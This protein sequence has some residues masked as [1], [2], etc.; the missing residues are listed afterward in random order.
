MK[1]A[2]DKLLY[3][4]DPDPVV[5]ARINQ[6]ETLLDAELRY[7]PAAAS[8]GCVQFLHWKGADDGPA[9]QTAEFRALITEYSTIVALLRM[10]ET[11]GLGGHLDTTSHLVRP[12]YDGDKQLFVQVL[13]VPINMTPRVDPPGVNKGYNAYLLA[14]RVNHECAKIASW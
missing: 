11:C 10:A 6:Y 13:S 3:F 9:A 1:K 2:V 5:A 7:G 14:V 8:F 4:R 12:L